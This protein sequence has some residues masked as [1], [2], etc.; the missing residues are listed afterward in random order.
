V[1]ITTKIQAIQLSDLTSRIAATLS[2]S[3]SFN[4]FWVVADVS[5]HTF[6]PN[7][8]WHFFDLVEKD[9]ASQNIIAKLS[10]VAWR[11]GSARIRNFETVTGQ[12][13]KAGIK[14]CLKVQVE[15]HQSY[16]LK[17]VVHDIDPAYTI[18]QLEVYRQATINRLLA[19]CSSYIQKVG[20]RLVSQN[21]TLKHATVI[22]KIA[23]ISSSSSAG[24]TDFMDALVKNKY[25]YHFVVN[26]YF[27]SVQG[28]ANAE[29]AVR[30][31]EEIC[32][33]KMQF[34]AVV[35]IR[36]GGADTDFLIF[37]QFILCEAVAKLHIPVITGIGHLK[38]QSIVD[39]LA[40]TPT[41]TP[42]KAAEFIIAHNLAFE[43]LLLSHQKKII[44]KSQQLVGKHKQAI[45]SQTAAI[46]RN[47]R[48]V[49]NEKKEQQEITRQKI[50]SQTTTLLH[51]KKL[52]LLEA[53]NKA[54]NKPL[55][56]IATQK[57]RVENEA[58]GLTKAA[59]KYFTGQRRSLSEFE[60][61][62]RLMSPVNLLKK[63]FA[64][65]YYKDEII[66]DGSK[67]ETGSAI[68]VRLQDTEIHSTITD[69]KQS[70]GNPFN[71]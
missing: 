27:T 50:I 52:Q 16:G 35:I 49:M 15:F 57:N 26:S 36:G 48:Q 5:N 38:N 66:T 25:G 62:F 11:P 42:T 46:T 54:L 2:D 10:A 7:Q 33:T 47:A 17:V 12:R 20:D 22:Q 53:S 59:R 55:F 61:I 63:G 39:L 24:Y 58:A 60:T 51:H 70:D 18:G 68:K 71:I 43:I 14:V 32:N 3:F 40:H 69:K 44:I 6:K 21:S 13:F 64:M 23:V 8:D 45:F 1:P 37:D 29:G 9:E 4:H 56:S 34:D 30:K 41:N 67:L 65:V 19:E 28:E 31:I